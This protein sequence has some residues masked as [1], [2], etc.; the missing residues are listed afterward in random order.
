[1]SA[2]Q[3][4]L[5][6]TSAGRR[7]ELLECFRSAAAELGVDLRIF[8]CDQFPDW[9][10]ACRSADDA[11]GVP[12]VTD[13]DY[14][15]TLLNMCRR[16]DVTMLVPTIDP[17]LAPLSEARSLFE[18]IG[19][20]AVVSSPAVI[21]IAG[22]KLATAELLLADGIDS[23]RTATPDQVL[24]M[25]HS[26]SWPLL[27]K[28]RHGSSGRSVRTVANA[29]E[30]RAV[31]MNEPF[32]V[33]ELLRGEEYTV[34]MFVDRAGHLRCAVPH[35]RVQIRAGEVEKGVTRRMPAL[36]EMAHRIAACLPGARGALCFQ[37]MVD[38]DGRCPAFEINGRF[39]GGYPLAHRAGAP[40]ARWLLEEA[41]DAPSSAGDGW[42][43]GVT[44]LR[45]DAAI[46]IEP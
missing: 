16:L 35:R 15:P 17:E 18:A 34:N 38:E 36:A 31:A 4:R 2:R 39:G 13:P 40:F 11:F 6:L 46:F 9:S 10:A 28:P 1:M 42:R 8:A 22:D 43:E 29:G 12:P 25:P 21:R 41:T 33:Q 27:I 19:V 26:W 32:V 44:M 30:L 20:E 3:I 45:Y 14:V 24:A 7:V 23:P 5:L 37:S